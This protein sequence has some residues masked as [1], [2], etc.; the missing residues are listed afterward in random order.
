MPLFHLLSLAWFI[1]IPRIHIYIY[2]YIYIFLADFI[3][4]GISDLLSQVDNDDVGDLENKNPKEGKMS[5]IIPNT[6]TCI[7]ISQK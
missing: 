2:I 7:K 3:D 5:S 6:Y 4:P 1:H